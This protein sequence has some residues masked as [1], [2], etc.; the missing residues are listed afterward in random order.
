MTTV[1]IPIIYNKLTQKNVKNTPFETIIYVR[2]D[3]SSF[4]IEKPKIG[5]TVIAD[6][7]KIKQLLRIMYP[8][9]DWEKTI[10]DQYISLNQN[11]IY[12]FLP[13]N[14]D[15][16][17]RVI[18]TFN[19]LK[20]S[21]PYFRTTLTSAGPAVD[22]SIIQDQPETEFQTY[23]YLFKNIRPFKTDSFEL[24]LIEPK[25]NHDIIFDEDGEPIK[26]IQITC[27]VP[28][29]KLYC[30][31]FKQINGSTY[32]EMIVMRYNNV[33]YRFPYGN[34]YNDDRMCF[35]TNIQLDTNGAK[36]E[37]IIY[38]NVVTSI[39]NGDFSPFLNFNNAIPTTLDIDWIREQIN[40][41]NFKM[42]FIDVLLYLSTCEKP[43][44]VNMKIFL[45]SPNIP[46]KIQEDFDR[47]SR[48]D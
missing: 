22:N 23:K 29:F 30:T 17:K 7:L 5:K 32:C 8:T 35:G 4:L 47:E 19:I 33:F 10:N 48:E 36:V 15:I 6:I 13:L 11:R 20:N 12:H 43:E 25:S 16:F 42:S 27:K 21:E 45:K 46:Q 26:K 31:C 38:S 41:D 39:Y 34:V 44:D 9:T 2:D 40:V 3:N 1:K 28:I 18:L 37:D 24:E 14:N